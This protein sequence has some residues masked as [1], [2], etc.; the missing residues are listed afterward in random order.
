MSNKKVIARSDIE[1]DGQVSINIKPNELGEFLKGLLGQN[2][3]V[4]RIFHRV[5]IIEHEWF[6]QLHNLI[7]QRVS[8]QNT[9]ELIEFSA[10]I[11][12]RNG[13]VLLLKSTEAFETYNDVS[14]H[15]T[16]AVRLM[17]T[18]LVNFPNKDHPEK[19]EILIDV[20]E[21][22]LFALEAESFLESLLIFDD[23]GPSRIAAYVEFT[24]VTFGEDIIALISRHVDESFP[25]KKS[26]SKQSKIF[27]HYLVSPMAFGIILFSL[28]GIYAWEAHTLFSKEYQ[29]IVSS[30]QSSDIAGVHKKIDYITLK[31]TTFYGFTYNF[32]VKS[33]ALISIVASFVMHLSIHKKSFLILN[34][35]DQKLY[36]RHKSRYKF[37]YAGVFLSLIVGI[38]SGLIANYLPSLI[39]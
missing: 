36:E 7:L 20:Y 33:F 37:L 3:N 11:S 16:I 19:Q 22:E 18:F 28:M 23:R 15:E 31:R 12:Y 8:G 27:P 2:R 14:P 21:S 24:E 35:A 6:M 1:T 9:A 17:W 32:F 5:F 29:A 25:Q 26:S 30:L 38:I 4:S 13:R 34:N 10:R 39:G